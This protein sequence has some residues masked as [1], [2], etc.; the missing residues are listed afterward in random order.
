MQNRKRHFGAGLRIG[1]TLFMFVLSLPLPVLADDPPVSQED[2]QGSSMF[3]QAGIDQLGFTGAASSRLPIIVPPGRN[4]IAPNI[5]LT[6]NSFQQNGPVGV[7]WSLDMGSIQRSTKRGVNYSANDFVS[8]AS[9]ELVARSDWG[10]NYYGARLESAYTKYYFD[11]STGGW[12]ATSREG[13]TSYYGSTSASRQDNAKG[14]FKWC[15]D[16]V[17]DTNG[18]TMTVTYTKDQGDIYI[19]QIQYTGHTSGLSPSNSVQFTYESRPDAPL[20]FSINSGVVTAN[21]LKTIEIRSL[22]NEFVRKYELSYSI[23]PSTGRSLLNTVQQYGCDGTSSVQILGLTW[24]QGYDPGQKFSVSGAHTVPGIWNPNAKY[25][26][27]DYNGDGKTDLLVYWYQNSI[28]LWRANGDG[29][30][31]AVYSSGYIPGTDISFQHELISLVALDYNGDGKTDL[32]AYRADGTVALLK[33]NGDGTFTKEQDSRSYRTVCADDGY[34]DQVVVNNG[35]AGLITSPKTSDPEIGTDIS[36]RF[37]PFDYNSDGKGDILIF[38]PSAGVIVVA[39][40]NGDGTFTKEYDTRTFQT[41]CDPDFGCSQQIT[42]NGFVGL[43][44]QLLSYTLKITSLDYNG[45]GKADLMLYDS[46]VLSIAK[47]NGDGTFTPEYL[48]TSG[49][50]FGGSHLLWNDTLVPLDYNGDGKTDFIR[51]RVGLITLMKSNGDGTFTCEYSSTTNVAGFSLN[52]EGYIIVPFDYNGDGMADLLLYRPGTGV[53]GIA[54]SDGNGNFTAEYSSTGGMGGFS[55]NRGDDRVMAL[56]SNGDG[57]FDL[58]MYKPT[59]AMFYVA[60]TTGNTPDLVSTQVNEFGGTTTLT[61]DHSSSY[62]NT[63]MPFVV[64]PIAQIAVADGMGNTATAS[65]TYGGGYFDIANREYRG[66]GYV[67]KTLTDGTWAETW[68]NQDNYFKG[69]S[70]RTD[71]KTAGGTLFQRTTFTWDKALLNSSVDCNFIYPTQKRTESYDDVTVWTQEDYTN[72][73]TANGY[74]LA[75]TTSGTD[76]ENVTESYQYTNMGDWN[77]RLAQS[78]LT[79]GTTG[80]VRG[81]LY[82][83]YSTTGNLNYKENWLS[84]GTNPRITMTYDQYGNVATITDPMGRQTTKTYDGDTHTYPVTITAPA[85]GSVSHVVQNTGYDTRFGKVTQTQGEDGNVTNY[86]YDVFGRPYQVNYPNGGQ[87]TVLFYDNVFPRY[88]LTKIKE[89]AAGQTIDQYTFADGL[90]RKVETINIGEAAKSI[91]NRFLY[92]NMGRNYRTEGPFFGSGLSYSQTP[93]ADYPWRE[94][95]Y[96]SRGRQ[97]TLTS[98]KPNGQSGTITSTLSYSGLSVT[99]TDPDGAQKRQKKDYLGRLIQ[100]TEFATGGQQNTSYTYNAAGDLLTT[101]DALGNITTITYDTERKTKEGNST[102]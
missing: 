71:S 101:T 21:R 47:A 6:Y 35:F 42:K 54:K 38:Q 9:G 81:T 5:V 62:Q 28:S 39:K 43:S 85:T 64:H 84:G 36:D 8:S 20:M 89:N 52:P 60:R 3:S 4:G 50:F 33:S 31:T 7:G 94:M 11:S 18:N 74:L 32:L 66:F 16:K 76:A 79:G 1:I 23:S 82:Q 99:T 41:V 45:D 67:K 56:D 55:L 75:K 78:T 96:D 44:P 69:K 37:I 63:Y 51:Y 57:K 80:A 48:F 92:D 68:Y 49:A 93:P 22:N 2:I 53:M 61:Y 100:V 73:D 46:G 14:V 65:Y 77:W 70:Y 19:S 24:Q 95:A 27:L 10:S 30:Y 86:T 102:I 15:L 58:L 34:C 59:D 40:S 25:V 17:Q 83:Y 87:T 26:P 98:P 91:V 13:I 72:Y 90:G 88:S 97:A 12:V 29:T